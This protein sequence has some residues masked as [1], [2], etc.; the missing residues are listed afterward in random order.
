MFNRTYNGLI[1]HFDKFKQSKK[2]LQDFYRSL[3]LN[4]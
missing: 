1:E 4:N 2:G 3:N